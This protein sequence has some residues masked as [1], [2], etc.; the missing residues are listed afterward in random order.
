[1]HIF[2]CMKLNLKEF[3]KL[4]G[5][6][7]LLQKIEDAGIHWE[8]QKALVN[9]EN[10][11][12]NDFL[13]EKEKDSIVV[14]DDM[15]LAERWKKRG[16]CCIGYQ[17]QDNPAFFCGAMAVISSFEELSP[18]FFLQIYHHF[19][20]IPLMITE[21]ERLVIRESCMDDFEKLY[22]I[23][24]EEDND[25]YT[26]TMTED[27]DQEREK[28]QAYITHAY[29]YYGFGLWTVLEKTTG[30][31]LGRCGLSA[32]SDGYSPEGRVE[33]GYLIGHDYRGEGYALE[34]C[35]GILKLNDKIPIYAVIHRDNLPSVRL[36]ERLG[37]QF[38]VRLDDERFLY[39]YNK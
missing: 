14:T 27:Y 3:K 24:R 7:V 4:P 22:Q 12:A 5:T 21:T 6:S 36:A 23:S 38:Q 25:R 20:G 1:M 15:R 13:N 17:E 29:T 34:A 11:S 19:H 39:C 10:L 30:E 16:V 31:I 37:F 33:L 8:Y 35:S 28:F 9:S 32:V 2:F 26:E 18:A